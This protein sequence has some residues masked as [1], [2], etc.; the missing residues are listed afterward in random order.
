M[1]D[2]DV[3]GFG[4]RK[5]GEYWLHWGDHIVLLRDGQAPRAFSIVRYLKKRGEWASADRYTEAPESLS[6]GVDIGAGREFIDVSLAT[7]E[8]GARE[9]R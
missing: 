6:I 4:E 3:H 1:A 8:K 2:R 9:L 7:I 5:S